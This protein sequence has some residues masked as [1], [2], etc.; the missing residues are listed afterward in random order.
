MLQLILRVKKLTAYFTTFMKF[1]ICFVVHVQQQFSD[2]CNR[3]KQEITI[4]VVYC[5]YIT[6]YYFSEALE[7]LWSTV[8]NFIIII[9]VTYCRKSINVLMDIMHCLW[10]YAGCGCFDL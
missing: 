8:V 2:V 10:A 9:S 6:D 4:T 7:E 5:L 3:Y 1:T